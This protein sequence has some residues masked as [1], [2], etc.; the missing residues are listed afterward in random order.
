M[1]LHGNYLRASS[2]P[3][4]RPAF[5][6]TFTAGN[7]NLAAPSGLAVNTW[8]HLAATFDGAMVRLYVNGVQ[9]TSQAQ[10]TPLRAT[11]GTLQIGADSYAGENFVGRID[12]VRIYNRALTAA[13]IQADIVTPVGG[14]PQSDTTPPTVALTAPAAGSTVFSLVRVSDRK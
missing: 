3:N 5:G 6:G 9:V 11:T 2:T 7:Q 1:S 8:T 10:A 4:N 12:E 13:E 14:T